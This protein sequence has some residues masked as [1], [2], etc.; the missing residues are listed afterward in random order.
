[1]IHLGIDYNVPEGTLVSCPIDGKVS[2]V[3]H[4]HDPIGG[5]GGRIIIRSEHSNN[6]LLLAHLD[7]EGLPLR[8]EGQPIK[9]GDPLGIVAKPERNGG[10]YPH[11][12]AQGINADMV[13]DPDGYFEAL[14]GYDGWNPEMHSLYPHPG[15]II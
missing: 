6:Y 11:L 2:H 5:W 12:H 10:W 14:D 4:D 13:R 9:K 3:M 7:E 1:M 8:M 15:N